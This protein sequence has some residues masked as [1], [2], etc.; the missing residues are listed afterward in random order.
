MTNS[1]YNVLQ[2]P[3]YTNNDCY[4]IAWNLALLELKTFF[5]TKCLC[6]TS[7]NLAC[8]IKKFYISASTFQS[9]TRKTKLA[10]AKLLSARKF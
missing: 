7:T 3:P 8:S 5:D 6:V 4:I 1:T 2:Y 10:L 9:S